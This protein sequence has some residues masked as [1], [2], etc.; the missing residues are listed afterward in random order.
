MSTPD[1]FLWFTAFCLTI[2]PLVARSREH[3]ALFDFLWVGFLIPILWTYFVYNFVPL[4]LAYA[5]FVRFG[6]AV[7]RA[8]GSCKDGYSGEKRRG[9]TCAG[10]TTGS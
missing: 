2:P 8:V 10:K 4:Y 5:L 9:S 3:G 7:R 6:M 1:R